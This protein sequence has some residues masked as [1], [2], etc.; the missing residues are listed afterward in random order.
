RPHCT[1]REETMSTVGLA[2]LV[3]R[4]PVGRA[5]AKY[6]RLL[7]SADGAVIVVPVT[8]YSQPLWLVEGPQHASR[9]IAQGIP[10]YRIWTLAEL[11][12]L[13]GPVESLEEAAQALTAE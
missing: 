3:E 2:A 5:R 10:R 11:Q 9:L 13:L 12:D 4:L 8:Y 6:E 1:G 7:Q